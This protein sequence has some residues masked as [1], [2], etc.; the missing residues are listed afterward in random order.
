MLNE[1]VVAWWG[2]SFTAS[3]LD[4]LISCPLAYYLVLWSVDNQISLMKLVI[5]NSSLRLKFD[6]YAMQ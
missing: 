2:M 4:C 5:L 6:L 1:H 3:I